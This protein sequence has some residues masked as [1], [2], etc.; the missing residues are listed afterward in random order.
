MIDGRSVFR[1]M[2]EGGEGGIVTGGPRRDCTPKVGWNK[3]LS[4]L[5]VGRASRDRP[6]YFWMIESN[7]YG[8]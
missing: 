6:S 4:G 7:F 2:H 1:W 3:S 5:S 8:V